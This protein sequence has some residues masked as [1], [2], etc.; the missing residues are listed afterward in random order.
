MLDVARRTDDEVIKRMYDEGSTTKEIAAHF[1]V[2]SRAINLRYKKLGID[3]SGRRR[4]PKYTVNERFFDEWSADMAYVLG[5][6]LTDGHIS[7]NTLSITQKEIGPLNAIAS[8]IET[9]SK[10]YKSGNVYVLGIY[11]KSIVESL[12]KHG[13]SEK[14]SLTVELPEVSNAYLADFLRGIIDGDGW[15]HPKGYVVTITSGSSEFAAQLAERLNSVGFP[16]RVN[17]DGYAYR[18]KLSG[19]DEVRRLGTY[20]YADPTAFS[21]ERKRNRILQTNGAVN[22]VNRLL[23][24]TDIA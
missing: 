18:I 20:L 3:V 24:D 8:M 13:I 6:I 11:R 22:V 16:F 5:F 15:A 17:H 12:E 1:G 7:G 9:D 19:K 4:T 21:I 23:L 14:K 10:P 2:S